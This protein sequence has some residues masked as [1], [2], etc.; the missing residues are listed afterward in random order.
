STLAF[1]FSDGADRLIINCGGAGTEPTEL[2]AELLTAL[3]TTAAHST[4]TLGDLNSTAIH[5]DGSLGKGVAEVETSRDDTA[6]ILRVEGT[7]DGYARRLGL[8]H[9]RRLTL[10][11]DGRH[12]AGEERLYQVEGRRRRRGGEVPFAVRFHLH[13]SVQA[14]TTADGQGALLRI[15]GGGVWQFRCRGGQLQTEDSLWIDGTA[16]PH[17]TLQLVISGQT[18]AEGMT[19][20]WE[21]KRVG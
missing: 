12:L 20:S 7:H 9:E 13:P 8:I 6:G 11:P 1:E 10:S 15:R 14:T 16:R 3:R 18:P 17:A 19:I 2:P 21:M 5:Q 4:L